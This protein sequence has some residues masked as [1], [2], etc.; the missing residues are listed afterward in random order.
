MFRRTEHPLPELAHRVLLHGTGELVTDL[1]GLYMF[2]SYVCKHK[3]L[4]NLQKGVESIHL[5]L[6]FSDGIP[7]RQR[8]CRFGHRLYNRM[9]TRRCRCRC[10][11]PQEMTMVGNQPKH[12]SSASC[13][14]NII[15]NPKSRNG[16]NSKLVQQLTTSNRSFIESK[17][18][19]FLYLDN[20]TTVLLCC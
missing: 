15:R 9:A 6:K 18:F 11:V 14:F 1:L 4:M 12:T 7:V 10:P 3:T 2:R 20:F 17:C 5:Y 19:H 13:K 8:K 16:K